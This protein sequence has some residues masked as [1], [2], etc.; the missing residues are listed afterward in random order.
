MAEPGAFSIGKREWKMNWRWPIS[1]RSSSWRRIF[2]STR[3]L[4]TFV[5]EVV[6]RA[7]THTCTCAW[8]LDTYPRKGNTRVT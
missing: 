4:E 6:L 3:F 8:E 5:S 2:P 7:F 1:I